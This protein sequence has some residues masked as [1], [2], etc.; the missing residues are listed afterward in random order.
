MGSLFSIYFTF[1]FYQFSIAIW[2]FFIEI[3]FNPHT[4]QQASIKS[5]STCIEL[6]DYSDES[7]DYLFVHTLSLSSSDY[8]ILNSHG[9]KTIG[10]IVKIA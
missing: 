9:I 5:Y 4:R 3:F 7:F 2:L 1:I 10:T 6:I 8:S